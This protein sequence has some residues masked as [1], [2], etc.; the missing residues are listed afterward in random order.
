MEGP[1]RA[2]A[3]DQEGLFEVQIRAR[4]HPG[5]SG[6]K[7]NANSSA[8]SQAELEWHYSSMSWVT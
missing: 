8:H 7:E 4:S 5:P 6:F 1:D 3:A 2:D